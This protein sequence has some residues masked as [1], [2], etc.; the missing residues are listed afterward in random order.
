MISLSQIHW[1]RLMKLSNEY[2]DALCCERK[3]QKTMWIS[4]PSSHYLVDVEKLSE[5]LPVME[6]TS[7]AWYLKFLEFVK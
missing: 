5:G 4:V 7:V 2:V 1:M 3:K 6:I